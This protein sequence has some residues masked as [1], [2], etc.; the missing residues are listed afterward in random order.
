MSF[1]SE[2]FCIWSFDLTLA[3]SV[4]DFGAVAE[5]RNAFSGSALSNMSFQISLFFSQCNNTESTPT[6]R[7]R[8]C[9]SHA[10]GLL[11]DKEP[12]RAF[13]WLPHQL[14]IALA[15]IKEAVPS[16]IASEKGMCI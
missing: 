7:S 5:K 11:R 12:L 15:W 16:D 14:G 4:S 2:A 9:L 10:V 6:R 3:G 8:S 1:E 13:S